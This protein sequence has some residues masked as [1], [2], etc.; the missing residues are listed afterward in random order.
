[1]AR[2]QHISHVNCVTMQLILVEINRLET[3]AQSFPFLSL[4]A[5]DINMVT[6]EGGMGWSKTM[7]L[8]HQLADPSF[9][10]D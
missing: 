8:R 2:S 5:A 1:M 7:G 10:I 3:K 6:M 4:T 9:G